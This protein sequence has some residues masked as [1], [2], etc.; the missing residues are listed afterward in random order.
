M[1]I[2]GNKLGILTIVVLILIGGSFAVGSN[3]GQRLMLARTT[4]ELNGVQAMLAFN[5]IQDERHL[6][7][8]ISRGCTDQA[9]AFLDYSE[10]KDM[11]LLSGFLKG[12]IDADTLK[13]VHDRDSNL[14]DTLKT[15]KSKYGSS[16]FEKACS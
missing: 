15:F 9:A 3:F 16:W 2:E 1:I 4:P 14:V 12:K 8:L 11:Q 6:Q 13:Y 5:R 7:S 10:D